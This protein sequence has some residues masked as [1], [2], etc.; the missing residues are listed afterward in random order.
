MAQHGLDA[1]L[2]EAEAGLAATAKGV[3]A[4]DEASRW[5]RSATAHIRAIAAGLAELELADRFLAQPH[6]QA[7]LVNSLGAAPPG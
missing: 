7:V 1:G 4:A 3:G 6:I 2:W 5:R